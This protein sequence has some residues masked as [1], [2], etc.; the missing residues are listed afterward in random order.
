MSRVKL[1]ILI[2]G[3]IC[4]IFGAVGISDCIKIMKEDYKDIE[5]ST[6]GGLDT[7]DLAKGK[8]Y[9]GYD[10]I[11]VHKTSRSYGFIPMGSS[12]EPYYVVKINEHFVVVSAANKDVQ[13]DIEKLGNE[14]LSYDKGNTAK[15]PTPVEVTTKVVDMPDKVREYLRDYFKEIGYTDSDIAKYVEDAYVF[16]CVDY[17]SMKKIPFIGFGLGAL[18]III[19]VILVVKGKKGG[20][21]RTVYV[22]EDPTMFNGQ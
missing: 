12:E 9:W 4:L 20:P 19:F 16:E 15:E 3:I 7:G 6:I 13:K 10:K 1:T 8:L 22:G 2:L 14:T 17:S 5:T 11:A 21:G 18:F